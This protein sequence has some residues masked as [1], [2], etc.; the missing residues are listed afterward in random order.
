MRRTSSKNRVTYSTFCRAASSGR[1]IVYVR[2]IDMDSGEIIATRSTGIEA[3]KTPKATEKAIKPKIAEL[4]AELDLD[5]IAKVRDKM[6]TSDQADDE[7][8]AGMSIYDF[9]NWF[10]SEDWTSPDFVDS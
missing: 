5:A 7:R 1:P 8:L 10:W 4:L 9:V 3:E 2:F 6:Q